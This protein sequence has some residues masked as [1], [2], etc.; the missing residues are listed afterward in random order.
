MRLEHPLISL[1][2]KLLKNCDNTDSE[3]LLKLCH[4][5]QPS[6]AEAKIVAQNNSNL[7]F[8]SSGNRAWLIAETGDSTMMLSMDDLV[9]D[10]D[11]HPYANAG[12]G[13]TN[14]G[15]PAPVIQ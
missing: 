6:Q 2:F 10:A 13:Q 3:Q 9:Q 12:I 11:V 4:D 7:R 15:L 1:L 5:F 14:R 8:E